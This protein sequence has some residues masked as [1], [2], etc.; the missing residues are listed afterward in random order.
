[1][2]RRSTR[3]VEKSE[4]H[5]QKTT[6]SETAKSF[7]L[8]RCGRSGKTQDSSRGGRKLKRNSGSDANEIL[9][10]SEQLEGKKRKTCSQR[11]VVTRAAASK[12]SKSEGIKKGG[13]R[14]RKRVYYQKVIFDGG[15]FEVGEDVYVKRRED[16]SSDDEDPEVEEC[17][18]CFK[19][20]KAIMIECDDCLGGFHLKC[21][22]P[23]LKEVPEGDWICG[24]CEATKT[25][26]QVQLPKPP[27][28]KKRVR[29]M[30]EKLLAGDLWAAHIER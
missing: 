12:N 22:K 8:E 7:K 14:P 13:G 19:S 26:K 4:L 20:G 15:E 21:L 30:R 1:M 5:L 17:R 3:L 9:F 25:G 10:S 23:S 28:G 27:E 6:S 11:A 16:A 29:T 24:F 18:V 2:S